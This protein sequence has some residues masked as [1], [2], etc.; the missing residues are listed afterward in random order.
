ML[1]ILL[2]LAPA[3]AGDP[4]E[5]PVQEEPAGEVAALVSQTAAEEVA[6]APLP[7]LVIYPGFEKHELALSVIRTVEAA[8]SCLLRGH[9]PDEPLV[10][11]TEVPFVSATEVAGHEVALERREVAI[12]CRAAPLRRCDIVLVHDSD[13]PDVAYA[14]IQCS[15]SHDDAYTTFLV[16]ATLDLDKA[17]KERR[18]DRA[19]ASASVTFQ[20]D[21]FPGTQLSSFTAT[22][23][24]DDAVV[25]EPRVLRFDDYDTIDE[26]DRAPVEPDHLF[27]LARRVVDTACQATAATC[28]SAPR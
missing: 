11:P 6:T 3:H 25:A 2:L 16:T 21:E 4:V 10:A 27:D 9:R 22:R 20:T 8:R 28:P 13:V 24:R 12:D 23:R 14:S 26:V 5:K 15:G 1:S 19:V 17:R 7:E 18:K